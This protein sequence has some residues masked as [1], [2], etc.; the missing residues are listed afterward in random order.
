MRENAISFSC[1]S[2]K[3]VA[4]TIHYYDLTNLEHQVKQLQIDRNHHDEQLTTFEKILAKIQTSNDHLNNQLSLTQQQLLDVQKSNEV[5]QTN[6]THVQNQLALTQRQL[7]S[8]QKINE[9]LQVNYTLIQNELSATQ[10]QLSLT[11]QQL[12]GVQ[13]MVTSSRLWV[14]SHGQFTV[15]REIGRGAWATV[16]KSTFRGSIVAAKCLHE[17]INAS[18]TRQLFQREME[19]AL[20]CQHHNVVTFLGATLKEPLV[21]L[22]EL[23]DISLRKAYEQRNIKDC[24]VLGILRDTASA[25]HF[26]HTRPDPVIHRDVSSANVLLKALYNGEWLAKLGD[27]GTATIQQYITTPGP[28]ALVYAAPE[29]ANPKCHSTKMDVYSFGVLVIEVLTKTLPFQNLRLLKAQVQRQFPQ[30]HQLV[31]SCTNQLSSDR[32]SMFEVIRQLNK[33]KATRS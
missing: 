8:L 11:Q 23:M 21:I 19:I 18:T 29:V 12:L 1:K 3:T 15:G 4:K 16:H 20:Q 27:L 24:Q 31:T 14:V 26:L 6:S 5:L 10:N 22:M 25:L 33:I 13:S 32:P 9:V 28:G 2:D 7:L 17:L 30:Y